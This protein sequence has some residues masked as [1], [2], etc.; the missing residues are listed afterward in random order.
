[1]RWRS[2]WRRYVGVSERKT[3][4][5]GT[6]SSAK[7]Q[8]GLRPVQKCKGD[9]GKDSTACCPGGN[10][11]RGVALPRPCLHRRARRSLAP[12]RERS[13]REATRSARNADPARHEVKG[14]TGNREV[15]RRAEPAAPPRPV[16][17][18][19]IPY[20][21]DRRQRGSGDRG[22]G[23][24]TESS[25]NYLTANRYPPRTARGA[26]PALP[27]D[28]RFAR[29]FRRLGEAHELQDG[30]GDVG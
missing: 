8:I 6:R 3:P 4:R 24:R 2:R 17:L 11:G 1:M 29:H 28:Q 5:G 26:V 15:G 19:P 13:S 21:R 9:T 10:Q 12:T 20:P 27:C 14:G 16:T 18:N 23:R 25:P 22:V 30:R 7:V